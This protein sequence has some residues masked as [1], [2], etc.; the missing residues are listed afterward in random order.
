[1]VLKR[2]ISIYVYRI[3]ELITFCSKVNI[4]MAIIKPINDNETKQKTI[5]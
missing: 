5:K 1:M 2:V 4:S 3:F